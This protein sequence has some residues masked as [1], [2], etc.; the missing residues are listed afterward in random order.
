LSGSYQAIV[1]STK[2]VSVPSSV[3]QYDYIG[4]SLPKRV[5]L[6]LKLLDGSGRADFMVTVS[7]NT[8]KYNIPVSISNKEEIRFHN[9]GLQ[10]LST[11]SQ[12]IVMKRPE[13]NATGNITVNNLYVPD[14][15]ERDVNLRGLNTSLDHSDNHLTIHKNA[16]R[17]QYVTY[18][19]WIQ[20]KDTPE[21]KQIAVKIP[22]DISERA[23]K[24]GVEV[25]WEEIM[26]SKNGIIL[27]LSVVS[28]TTVALW[29]LRPNMK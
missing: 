25:P 23:K 6:M 21:D 26:V 19:K 13:I 17:M 20:T 24:N 2:V 12:T 16:S 11:E 18:F 1:E 8:G 3:S 22:G 4:I 27:L 28:V 7:N 29:R 5:D 9:I 14:R 10:D 15:G